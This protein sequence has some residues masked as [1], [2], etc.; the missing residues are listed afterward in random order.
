MQNWRTII[1]LLLGGLL[2]VFAR[3]NMARVE[4]TFLSWTFDS[5]RIAVAVWGY[6]LIWFLI[7]S[8]VKVYVHRLT[9]HRAT[10]QIRHIERIEARLHP[11]G[12]VGR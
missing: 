1:A 6:A 11:R 7:N 12:G 2:G 4:L 8:P 3:Q 5:R 10:T 9:R